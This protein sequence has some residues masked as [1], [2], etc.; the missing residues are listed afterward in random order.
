MIF[1][2]MDTHPDAVFGFFYGL[3]FAGVIAIAYW[4]IRR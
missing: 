2:M 1:S 3:L 4:P